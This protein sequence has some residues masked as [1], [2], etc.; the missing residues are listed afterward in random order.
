MKY[1]YSFPMA[2][3]LLAFL[4]LQQRADAQIATFP[5]F[6]DFETI[7]ITGA[8]FSCFTGPGPVL[9]AGWVDEAPGGRRW[10]SENG[11]TPSSFSTGPLGGSVNQVVTPGNAY[12]FTEASGCTNQPHNLRSPEFDFSAIDF[13]PALAFDYHLRGIAMGNLFLEV[14][15]DGPAGPWTVINTLIGLVENADFPNG[16]SNWKTA[17]VNL[18]AYTG[19]PSVYFRL[20]G[21]TGTTFNSDMAIDNFTIFPATPDLTPGNLIAPVSGG[22][23][24]NE[25]VTV[26]I[27]NVGVLPATGFDVT[28]NL[29][30]T[31][32][33]AIGINQEI[34]QSFPDVTIADG[35]SVTVTLDETLNMSVKG[36]YVLIIEVSSDDDPNDTNNVGQ[37]LRESY[38]VVDPNGYTQ[39]WENGRGAWYLNPFLFNF[40]PTGGIFQ[41]IW[42][43]GVPNNTIINEASD[44]NNAYA[45][46]LEENL[47]TPGIANGVSATGQILMSPVFNFAPYTAADEITFAL[48]IN[49]DLVAN[50]DLFAI[51]YNVGGA[52]NYAGPDW[53][54]LGFIGEP[55]S[56]NWY[57][58]TDLVG[59]FSW[60]GTSNGWKRAVISIE[61]GAIGVPIY[62]QP[63]V[64]FGIVS[65][66]EEEGIEFF[67]GV[68]FPVSSLQPIEGAAVDNFAI[69]DGTVADIAV[70]NVI[71]PETSANLNAAQE[72]TIEIS[73]F[74]A[75]DVSQF[76]VSFL[77]N[78]PAGVSTA[79][80]NI[81]LTV[82]AFGSANYTFVGKANLSFIGAYD[83]TV[84]AFPTAIVDPFPE[85]NTRNQVVV[86]EFVLAENCLLNEDF[87]SAAGTAP[88]TGWQNI[89][90]DGLDAT[91][92][93]RFDNPGG[94]TTPAPFS[95]PLAILDSDVLGEFSGP[96][97]ASLITPS[98]DLS[99]VEEGKAVTFK[100]DHYFNSSFGGGIEVAYS[101]D[102]GE[103]WTVLGSA[104]ALGGGAE[105]SSHPD[106]FAVTGPVQPVDTESFDL[107]DLIGQESLQ[108]RFRWVGDWSM[109]WM[110]DNISLCVVED[111]PVLAAEGF[112]FDSVRVEWTD[113]SSFNP[114]FVLQRATR[115]NE[116]DSNWVVVAVLPAGQ[117][118]YIDSMVIPERTYFYRVQYLYTDG[119]SPYSNI[120]SATMESLP[121]APPGVAPYEPILTGEPGHRSA[122]LSWNAPDED[123]FIVGFDVYGFDV[124]YP[125]TRVGS[126]TTNQFTV[127]NLVNGMTYG[128]RIRPI[129]EDGTLGEFSNGVEVRPSIVLANEAESAQT[130][131]EVFP[132]PNDG[133]FQVRIQNLKGEA[134]SMQLVNTSGQ[135][136]WK[137][138]LTNQTGTLA[139]TLSL[140]QLASGLYILQVETENEVLN[141]KISIQK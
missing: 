125:T 33:D 29:V 114:A 10:A 35:A 138:Q 77:I 101:T 79:T 48:D 95:A 31:V 11:G 111:L 135:L 103:E 105:L 45:T 84:S 28:V 132:N 40:T 5:Y 94:R 120:D 70:T 13:D 34:S 134:K 124:R 73:N 17:E 87:A 109:F 65:I 14:S 1:I 42:E 78:G 89:V 129:F 39:S 23:L 131:L 99:A 97:D 12:L 49:H 96:E 56:R 38:L 83:F 68:V 116:P 98:L 22:N 128:F 16:N 104:G 74:G 102:M 140:P 69:T 53:T 80:E 93:W 119:L 58:G 72:V 117:T 76:E 36:F 127:Q 57:D 113:N 21:V 24:G 92:T 75:S 67:P 27:E 9:P 8:G 141:H 60:Q 121:D 64:R 133:T 50:E 4:G 59:N 85:N 110:L 62:G 15:T 139:E 61:A 118:T 25:N 7:S 126:T 18:S 63:E 66:N 3:L 136:V 20:R 44:G 81:T 108:F 6:E 82:P 90:A 37:I 46:F 88:P 32:G 47:P 30:G 26:T 123:Q 43:Q 107:S 55:N 106:G 130:L 100:F 2:I 112:G 71:V 19:E 54:F 41:E 137:K 51:V 86:H 52:T 91:A 115:I 122:I